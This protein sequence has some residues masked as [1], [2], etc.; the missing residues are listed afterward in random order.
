MMI[1]PYRDQVITALV[2]HGRG[3]PRCKPQ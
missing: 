1:G 2:T 3:V